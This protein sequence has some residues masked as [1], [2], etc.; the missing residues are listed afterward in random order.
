MAHIIWDETQRSERLNKIRIDFKF[1]F[2]YYIFRHLAD[3]LAK[4]PKLYRTQIIIGLRPTPAYISAQHHLS[5]RQAAK[6]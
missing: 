5:L 4:K 3:K 2:T 1:I 6:S